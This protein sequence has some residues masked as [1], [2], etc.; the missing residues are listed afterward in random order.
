MLS[1]RLGYL[2]LFGFSFHKKCVVSL[3]CEINNNRY[4]AKTIYTS[5]SDNRG[6]YGAISFD[7]SVSSM[8]YAWNTNEF[9]SISYG[10]RIC[11]TKTTIPSLLYLSK[12]YC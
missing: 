12:V 3:H 7:G 8:Q 2:N 11:H 1:F 4:E 6:Y 9:D 10:H 5:L